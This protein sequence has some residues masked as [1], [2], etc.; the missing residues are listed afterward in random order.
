[1]P[2]W[3]KWLE[4]GGR[5]ATWA[6]QTIGAFINGDTSEPVRRL[7]AILPAELKSDV[8]HAHQ[9]ALTQRMLEKEFPDDDG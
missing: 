3:M 8:E 2:D 6:V 7:V 9:R 1:M 5:V 4:L